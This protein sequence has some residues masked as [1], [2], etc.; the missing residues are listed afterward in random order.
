[1]E[2]PTKAISWNE[3]EELAQELADA[4]RAS[5]FNPDYLFGIAVGGLVPLALLS[6][7][8]KVKNVVTIS[9]H[10][11]EFDSTKRGELVVTHMPAIDVQGKKVLLID[12]IADSGE[13]LTHLARL[14]RERCN[15]G[16]LK[17]A[18]LVVHQE[19]CKSRP[20]FFVLATDQWVVFP[21][22]K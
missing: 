19:H 4:I 12:E 1:M 10:A 17:T 7:A 22:E 2:Q 9:A 3:I 15:I 21:W 5:G 18:T 6:R 11:Y 13:T 16:E 8:L 20:D 14:L